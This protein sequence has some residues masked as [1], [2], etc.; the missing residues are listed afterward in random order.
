MSED[1]E[2]YASGEGMLG[3]ELSGAEEGEREDDEGEGGGHIHGAEE[4]EEAM[5]EGG[6]EGEDGS[7]A[8]TLLV[9]LPISLQVSEQWW[10]ALVCH[11]TTA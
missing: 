8:L 10:R 7:P 4:E 2:G 5:G 6:E 11:R 3:E 9:P 1:E